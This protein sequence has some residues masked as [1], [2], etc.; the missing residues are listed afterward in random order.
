MKDA[1]LCYIFDR[2]RVLLQKKAAGRFGEGKWNAPGGKIRF[3]ETP[4]KAAVREVREETGL[5]V[6]K[7]KNVGL[8]NFMEEK[9]KV[10]SVH[11]FVT[12]YFAGE[13]QNGREG[14]LQWFSRE[15]LPYEEMW[16]DDKIWVP[17]LLEGKKFR[18]SFLFTKG[19]KKMMKHTIE[20]FK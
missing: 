9:G 14:K 19:F 20:E 13:I 1:T 6:T 5:E 8:L 3:A 10:F 12:E 17:Y 16:E 11:I 2:G 15:S 7:L 18:G 4:E